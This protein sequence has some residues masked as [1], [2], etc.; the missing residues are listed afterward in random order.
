MTARQKRTTA[1]KPLSYDASRIADGE[2][3][4]VA[5]YVSVNITDEDGKATEVMVPKPPGRTDDEIKREAVEYA[6]ALRRVDAAWKHELSPEEVDA[7]LEP[8][9]AYAA[10][11]ITKNLLDVLTERADDT[12][13]NDLFHGH[14]DLDAVIDA[15]AKRHRERILQMLR[16]ADPAQMLRD[17]QKEAVAAVLLDLEEREGPDLYALDEAE[18]DKRFTKAYEELGGERLATTLSLYAQDIARVVLEDLNPAEIELRA[19]V[20]LL[21]PRGEKVS[22]E[23]SALTG[24]DVYMPVDEGF[25]TITRWVAGHEKPTEYRDGYAVLPVVRKRFYEQ[26]LHVR[27]DPAY[28]AEIV[29]PQDVEPV[30]ARVQQERNE[31]KAKTLVAAFA[32]ACDPRNR[33]P[34]SFPVGV[35]DLV[36]LISGYERSGPRKTRSDYYERKLAEVLRYL[37]ADLASLQV[38]IRV[39]TTTKNRTPTVVVGEYLMH[40][41]RLAA[42]QEF[43]YPELYDQLRTLIITG[44]EGSDEAKQALDYLKR[45]KPT[46]VYLGFPRT[47]MATLGNDKGALEAAN[48]GVLQLNGPTF[49]L[50]Y[51]VAFRRRWS[52]PA[53][54]KTGHGVPLL[55]ELERHGFTAESRKRTGGRP[56]YKHALS[57]FFSSIDQLLDLGELDEPGVKIWRPHGGPGR[58]K[59]VAKELRQWTTQRG[60]RITEHDLEALLVVYNLPEERMKALAALRRSRKPRRKKS[61]IEAGRG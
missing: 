4:R 28:F 14:A 15:A 27:E 40:R 49:W 22:D 46:H 8:L 53:K 30:L 52:D 54:M 35:H 56:S 1:K 34:E 45:L 37:H 29:S 10:G 32:L 31:T 2:T 9:A 38:N 17:I 58:P 13:L 41:P 26:A 42:E 60:K 44:Q 21:K 43:A 50:A 24:S 47:I 20:D 57:A 23:R 11:V 12:E 51:D 6:R 48:R 18:Y 61:A 39:A 36:N 5:T 3:L 55:D 59:E 19:L 25:R 7:Y 33:S 16:E